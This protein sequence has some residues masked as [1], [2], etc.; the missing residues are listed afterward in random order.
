MVCVNG[1]LRIDVQSLLHR[2]HRDRG[3]HMVRRRHVDRGEFL[4]LVEQFALILV[5]GDV[6]KLLLDLSKMAEIDLGH[7]DQFEILAARQ[8]FDIGPGHAMARRNWRDT[9]SSPSAAWTC[10]RQ[11]KGAAKAL[12]ASPFNTVRRLMRAVVIYSL[13]CG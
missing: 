9:P 4:F 8:R 7:G 1:F 10:W 3:V 6:R 11:T 5:D 12:A 13:L 2:P